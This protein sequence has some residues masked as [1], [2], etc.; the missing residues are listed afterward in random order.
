MPLHSQSVLPDSSG[1]TLIVTGCTLFT[2]LTSIT[3]S[4]GNTWQ[5]STSASQNPPWQFFSSDV[6]TFVAWCIN[7]NPV[8]SV[9]IT[10]NGAS[11]YSSLSVSEWSG[12]GSEDTGVGNAVTSAANGNPV[13]PTITLAGTGELIVGAA[14]ADGNGIGTVPSGTNADSVGSNLAYAL[15]QSGSVQWTWGG[16]TPAQGTATALAAFLPASSGFT[17]QV[18]LALRSLRLPVLESIT[19][20]RLPAQL[21]LRSRTG[22][23]QASSG[24]SRLPAQ[25]GLRSR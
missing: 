4:A 1:N 12:I 17:G 3:D 21:R 9:T 2:T 18:Q 10:S 14:N 15:S 25:P 22:Q 6:A 20:S 8:T 5:Y 13:S 16:R 11:A 7:A 23:I 19:L 24:Q